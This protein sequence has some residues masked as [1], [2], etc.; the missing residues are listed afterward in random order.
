M[1]D[2]TINASDKDAVDHIGSAFV[3]LIRE[4]LFYDEEY[5][6]GGNLSLIDRKEGK[7]RYIS[8]YLP[9]T[10]DFVIE[11]ATEWEDYEADEDDEIGYALAVDSEDYG[12]YEDPDACAHVLARLVQDEGL[13]PSITLRFE[14]DD[15][16]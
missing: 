16:D 7:E 3:L 11:K 5:G 2:F 10:G 12:T 14:E 15:E 6:V 1:A 9:D 13:S 8:A 4:T